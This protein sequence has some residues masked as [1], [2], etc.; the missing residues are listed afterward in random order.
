[1]IKHALTLAAVARRPHPPAG[2]GPVPAVRPQPAD[3]RG[4]RRHQRRVHAATACRSTSSTSARSSAR[5][6]SGRRGSPG[7]SSTT[8]ASAASTRTR[9]RR[10]SCRPRTR[11]A[12]IE[13][14]VA[15]YVAAGREMARAGFLE[16][17][18]HAGRAATLPTSRRSRA[19]DRG[20]RVP[21][22]ARTSPGSSS[23]AAPRIPTTGTWASC[24]SGRAPLDPDLVRQAVERLLER[25]DALRMRFHA[26]QQRLGGIDRARLRSRSHSRATTCP[27]CPATEQRA[28]IER[29][30]EELQRSLSLRARAAP[31]GRDVRPWAERPAAARDR[32]SLRHGRAVLAPIL[33]GLR[34]DPRRPRAADRR[35]SSAPETTSFAEWAHLLKQRAD[36]PELR[37]EIQAWLDL[38]WDDVRPLPL[39]HP[40]RRRRE[41]ERVGARGRPRVLGGRDA[42][43]IFQETPGVPHKVDFLVTALAAGGRRWTGSRTR[44]HRHDGPR[45]RRGRLRDRRPVRHRRVLHLVH[46]DGADARRDDANVGRASC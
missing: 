1:M 6:S 34:R 44:A 23:S 30:A 14:V 11:E 39:D 36:S 2:A 35:S 5:R 16:Q 13:A 18:R 3:G 42:G 45:P 20:A 32:P 25:H 19:P 38:P 21:A 27:A 33:G 22:A 4:R 29:H 40:S 17:R 43:R 12:D 37:G 41:H 7:C 28:A 24:S 26:G 15:A 31:P 9:R 8:S 10:R 46:A